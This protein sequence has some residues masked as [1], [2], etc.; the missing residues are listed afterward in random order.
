MMVKAFLREIKGTP[1]PYDLIRIAENVG[2]SRS[3]VYEAYKEFREEK[4]RERQEIKK[5]N[6][7]YFK[8]L[9]KLY[10]FLNKKCEVIKKPTPAEAKMIEDIENFMKGDFSALERE[11]EKKAVL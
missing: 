2:C 4:E 7:F 1:Y 8:Y 10:N 6:S 11:I 9:V 3:L 5:Y